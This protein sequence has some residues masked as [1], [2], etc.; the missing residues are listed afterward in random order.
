VATTV[1]GGHI[2]EPLEGRLQAVIRTRQAQQAEQH[3]AIVAQQVGL[4][5]VE[6]QAAQAVLKVVQHQ[7][8]ELHQAAVAAVVLSQRRLVQMGLLVECHSHT[9]QSQNSTW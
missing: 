6:E 1:K 2:P 5:Q 9:P 7:L 4:V 8:P 3:L